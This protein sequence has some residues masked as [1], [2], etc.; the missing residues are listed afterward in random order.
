MNIRVLT[1]E[2]AEAWWNLRLRALEEEP[3]AFGKSAH[4]HRS[5]PVN[6][7]KER[8]RNASPESF[9]M[10]AFSEQEMTGMVTFRVEDNAKER[11]KGRIYAFYVAPEERG[12]GVGRALLSSAIEYARRDPLVEQ[13]LL[14][15]SAVQQ[16][17]RILYQRIGF[18]RFGLEPDSLKVGERYIDEEHMI[19][20]LRGHPA[21]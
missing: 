21:T 7:V 1:E 14:A 3:L 20:R 19:L 12:K 10:G 15:V 6:V 11:H 18:L 8:L 5:V 2:D 9:T 17:A 4:E 16:S 13:V